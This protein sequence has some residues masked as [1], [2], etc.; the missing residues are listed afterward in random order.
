MRDVCFAELRG[1]LGI[2]TVARRK[3]TSGID[4]RLYK[5]ECVNIEKKAKRPTFI[6][7]EIVLGS[8]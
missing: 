2:V 6:E 8:C 7:H 1:F 3:I 5:F 4:H